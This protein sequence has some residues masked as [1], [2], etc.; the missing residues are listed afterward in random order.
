MSPARRVWP[1]TRK[2]RASGALSMGMRPQ[3][4]SDSLRGIQPLPPPAGSA[5]RDSPAERVALLRRHWREGDM[6]H[7][8]AVAAMAGLP[9]EQ[10]R[11]LALLPPPARRPL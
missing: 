10:A 1:A 2:K 11:Q 3:R 9:F 6:S 5:P 7:N 8:L 4:A